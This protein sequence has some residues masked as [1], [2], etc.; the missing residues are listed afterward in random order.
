MKI[1]QLKV[2]ESAAGYYVGRLYKD[3]SEGDVWMPYSRD[4]DYYATAEDADRYRATLTAY[5]TDTS[6]QYELDLQPQQ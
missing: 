2:L 1:S 3:R 4:S 6:Y 5:D